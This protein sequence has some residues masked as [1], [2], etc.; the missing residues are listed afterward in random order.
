MIDLSN[1]QYKIIVN[2]R[3]VGDMHWSAKRWQPLRR[4][5]R[6]GVYV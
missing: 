5:T 3:N 2:L 1:A 4:L 6:Q